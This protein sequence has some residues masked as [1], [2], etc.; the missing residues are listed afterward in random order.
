MNA[1]NDRPLPEHVTKQLAK[2]RRL[3]WWSLFFLLTIVLAMGLAAGA[4]QTMKSAW[5]EDLLSMVPAVLFLVSARIERWRPDN[6]FPYGFHRVGS[7]AFF[8]S[9]L[10]L[11]AVGG[12]L[13]YEAADTLLR[14]ARPTIGS[15]SMFGYDIWLG[16]VMM[17]AM[18][19]SVVP[20]VILGQMKKPLAVII[21]DKILHTDAA[22]NAADWRTGLAGM[23]GLVGI[24]WGFWWADAVAAGIIS[25]SILADGLANSRTALAELIDGA[26]RALDNGGLSKTAIR[27]RER[28]EA[29]YPGHHVRIRETGRYM[30]AV[31][32]A[33]DQ[34]HLDPAT[35]DDLLG[36]DGW[37]LVE[38]SVALPSATPRPHTSEVS[39]P[40]DS[41]D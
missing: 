21:N 18:A 15:V 8:A 38:V 32:V 6:R 40:S 12:L 41:A 7:L 25:V 4:S 29:D 30:R 24:A 22:M 28:L 13:V 3:E 9:A 2:A 19:Y 5:I 16:W 11:T 34:P 10:T 33:D 17:A 36:E 37:R 23:A 20:P 26:P 31:L 1:V 14:A 27:L 39:S 35:A